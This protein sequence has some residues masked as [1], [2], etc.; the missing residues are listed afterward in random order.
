MPMAR[1]WHRAP[2]DVS[3]RPPQEVHLSEPEKNHSPCCDRRSEIRR[4]R[5]GVPT[6][7]CE[8]CGEH[9]T[10]PPAMTDVSFRLRTDAVPWL[11]AVLEAGAR[12]GRHL[13]VKLR[14]A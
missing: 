12:P 14:R 6:F 4:I 9:W 13:R 5:D 3:T 10:R 1:K 2:T 8:K 7:R 11:L